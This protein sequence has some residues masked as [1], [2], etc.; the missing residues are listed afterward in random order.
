M[1]SEPSVERAKILTIEYCRIMKL[2]FVAVSCVFFRNRFVSDKSRD[3]RRNDL[4]LKCH[5][6]GSNLLFCQSVAKQPILANENN[7]K[8]N[9]KT[10]NSYSQFPHILSYSSFISYN[11]RCS[12]FV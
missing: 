6:F 12:G 7:N 8:N 9:N 10:I 1:Y 5:K 11:Y 4:G 2:L 3:S